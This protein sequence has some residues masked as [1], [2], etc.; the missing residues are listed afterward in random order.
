M[1]RL[2]LTAL[3][4]A[5]LLGA[6]LARADE[7]KETK[8][9]A[10]GS[11][12]ALTAE[13]AQAKALA[14]L[15]EAGKVDQAK[16][17]A[18]W[19]QKDR[20]ILD[21]LADTFALGNPEVAKML[22]NA[23]DVGIPA[24]VETPAILKDDKQS[25]FFR[26]NLA[27]A[28]SRILSTRKVHDEALEVLKLVRPEAVADPSAYLFFRAVNEH[29]LLLKADANKTINRL[30]RDAADAP[31][32]YKTVSMLMLLDMTTWKDKDLGD[33]ARK[34]KKV[35][36]R[37]D[38]ARAGDKTQKLQ[39]EIVS[40]LD[41]LIKELEN[42]AKGGGG[43]GGSG[44]PNEGGCPSGGP[45]GG[46]GPP[47]GNNPSSPATESG[48]SNAGGKGTVDPAK[49]RKL[50]EQWG[51]LPPR[52]QAKALQELTTGL[53]PRHREAIENYFRNLAQANTR[54]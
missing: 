52:E 8:E 21:K 46:S 14:W 39:K 47:Q 40:R 33:I 30:L 6:N 7:K 9:L 5:G 51:R 25:A 24:P 27:M 19:K 35:E 31:E 28:Y 36:D 34:M 45:P 37:L 17:D 42:K 54:K 20:T 50:M 11:L 1:K 44:P 23:R 32:R 12:E 38:L 41:E 10:F 48:I 16:F 26:S 2:L 22:A 49:M 13:A 4:S 43:G 3:L 29:A 15:K 53:S 18:I